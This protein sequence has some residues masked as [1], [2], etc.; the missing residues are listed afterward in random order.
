MTASKSLASSGSSLGC[1]LAGITLVAQGT[2][3][4]ADLLKPSAGS[5][6]MY[7]GDYSGPT[8]QPADDDQHRQRSTSMTLAWVYRP[9]PGNVP[10]GGGGQTAVTIKGTPV[11]ANGVMYVT[12]P[13]HVWALDARSG[14]ELWHATWPSKGGWHIGNRG[15]AVLGRTVYVETPDCNLVALD[16]R[17]GTREVADRDLRPR[18][19]LLRVRRAADR[20]QPRHRR[21]Q[22]RRS[23]HSRL[24]A[25]ARSGNRRAAVALVTSTP[26]RA[27]PRRR[28]GRASRR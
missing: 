21:R 9:N 23:R 27:R 11:V 1:P 16:T 7:N 4:P 28:P 5:W 10:A 14:R 13:D 24:P 25:V 22:R 26:S 19:V 3:T 2:V 12:I 20:R 8:L 15:V 18:A 6:P 17:D